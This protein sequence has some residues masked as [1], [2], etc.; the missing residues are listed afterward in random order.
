[1]GGIPAN[2]DMAS[3][4]IKQTFEDDRFGGVSNLRGR[5]TFAT[6]GA[7]TRSSQIF[8]NLQD[9]SFLD[10]QGF[11]PFAEV[12]GDGM[13]VFEQVY[14]GYGESFPKGAGPKPDM[15]GK[16]GESYL[17]SSFPKLSWVEVVDA[18][19]VGTSTH[20][21][22]VQSGELKVD[23]ISPW[24]FLRFF[25]IL[26]VLGAAGAVLLTKKNWLLTKGF[27]HRMSSAEK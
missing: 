6:A 15:I 21:D 11:T 16:H 8:I 10:S 7:N 26:G 14:S 22:A 5:L 20:F 17:Q 9:N 27:E 23:I 19:G 4:W 13:P 24:R 12:V 18:P 1:M 2:P 3:K 25:P